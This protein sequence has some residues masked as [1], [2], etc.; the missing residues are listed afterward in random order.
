MKLSFH[1]ATE[2]VTGSCF[3]I[4]TKNAKVLVD[5][6]M[7][8]GERMCVLRSLDEFG[9]NPASL[10]AVLVTHAH[11]D[12]TGRLPEL[13]KKGFKGPIFLTPPTKS[14]SG[15]ILDDAF[16]VMTENAKRCGDPVPF[17]RADE[18]KALG[19]MVGVN[20]HTEFEAAPG[21]KAMFH[22]AGH[23]LGSSFITLDIEEKM[24]K[25]GKPFRIA[26]SGDIGNDD[27]PILG[28][29]DELQAADVIVTESTYGDR[30]HEPANLRSEQLL[31]F[32]KKIIERRGTLIIPAFSVER[33]QELLYELDKLLHEG[34][35]PEVPIYLDSPL[36][37]RATELYRHFD[38]YLHFA[39]PAVQDKDFFSFSSL[40]ETL[41]KE[42]S[43]K[44]NDDH[45]S[46][47]IIAG[48]GM[49]TG[50]RVLHHL[51]RYLGDKKAGVLVIGFQA[52]GTL[53][54]KILDG[55]KEVKIYGNE[56][57]VEA[58]VSSIEAF[59][60]HGDRAKL[61]KWLHTKEGNAEKIFLVHGEG[62]TKE[63]FKKYVSQSLPGEVIIPRLHEVF[64]F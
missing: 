50:G 35:L 59:S 42:A 24:G 37:I 5:C 30:D 45:R 10:D 44:I 22:D 62:H 47:I 2:E 26:F 29:T 13:I 20:Y 28:Q 3:L 38:Q 25:K 39:H 8:Q 14:L 21:I 18:Q 33:T 12:H 15:I 46:K 51:I 60:A 55:E 16:S 40:R 31:A 32:A 11:F 64:E 63:S 53:G 27:V 54:R 7:K 56:I 6:G 49:M 61:L 36:A 48:N 41:Q 19:Q 17:E 52:G 57:K 34:K 43:I 4:E 23:I 9:F 1:G 58:E